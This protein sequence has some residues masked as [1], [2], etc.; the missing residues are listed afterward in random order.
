MDMLVKEFEST[1]WYQFVLCNSV[2]VKAKIESFCHCFGTEQYNCFWPK[3]SLWMKNFLQLA[4]TKMVA[5][6]SGLEFAKYPESMTEEIESVLLM[7]RVGKDNSTSRSAQ[8]VS[9]LLTEIGFDHE[10]KVSPASSISGDMLAIDFACKKQ[11]VAIE[12]DGE[13]CFLKAVE[14]WK[15]DYHKE[16]QDQSQTSAS[17]TTWMDC[18]QS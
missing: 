10:C 1:S 6:A 2:L 17:G 4:Y 14:K 13:H 5:T 9:K 11:M 15:V 18:Y 16:W 7:T 12:Y 3:Q 8:E